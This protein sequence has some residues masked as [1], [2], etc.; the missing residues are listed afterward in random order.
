MK[1]FR[2]LIVC[3]IIVGFTSCEAPHINPLDPNSDSQIG[4]IDGYVKAQIAPQPALSNVTVSWKNGNINTVSDANGYFKLSNVNI[5]NGYVYFE[6][7][8]YGK[9]SIF[10]NWAGNKN[11][12]LSEKLLTATIGQLD[13]YVKTQTTPQ[14]AI[15]NV[16]ITWGKNIFITLTDING[17]YKISNINM[18]NGY[19]YFEKDGYS[20]D[21]LLVNW[22]G[23]ND[24][25]LSPKFLTATIGQLDGYVKTQSLPQQAIQSVRITWGN[26]IFVTQTDIAGYYKISNINLVNG[27]LFFEKEGYSKDSLLV[28]WSGQNDLHLNNK[29]LNAIPQLKSYLIYTGVENRYPSDQRD[30][31]YVQAIVSDAENDVDSVSVRC[32][33]LNFSKKL[34]F[35]QGKNIYELTYFYGTNLSTPSIGDAI[36]KTFEIIVKDKFAKTFNLGYSTIK[37]IIRQEIFF[38]SPANGN[39]VSSKPV[40]RW[41]RFLPGYNYKY[42]VQIFSDENSPQLKWEKTNIS[43][44]D[45]EVVPEINLSKGDYYWVIW[46]VDDYQNRTRSKPASFS[47]Q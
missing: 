35:N 37:R 33:E 44:D 5:S 38:E 8:G 3:V 26:N 21:S 30:T 31:L 20:K 27:Y 40:L 23:Q 22:A 45:I 17:Y 36:G 10:V 29:T 18:N 43:K 24:I 6:K 9:D 11:V 15:Q 28:N 46:G 41:S 13:G 16:K 12:H 47:V 14:Q 7:F 34:K 39:T 1:I 42:M 25:H 19:L 32:S 4:V 2:S